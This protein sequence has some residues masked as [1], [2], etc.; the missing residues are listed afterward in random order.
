MKFPY[1]KYSTRILRPVIPIKVIYNNISV[2][3]EILVDSGA[4]FCVFDAEI[5]DILEID[6]E[7]GKKGEVAGV[8]GA[9]EPI[10]FHDLEIEVGSWRFKV[11]AAFLRKIGKFGYGIVGQKGFFDIFVV[12]FDLLKEEVDL[13]LRNKNK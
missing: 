2:P 6:V 1:K 7:K 12:K 5:A 8:T 9:N 4:D 10:Y 3:Y 13:K 11:K